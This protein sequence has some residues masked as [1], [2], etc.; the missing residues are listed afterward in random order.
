MGHL[1]TA[2]FADRTAFLF[3]T[4]S[5]PISEGHLLR[6]FIYT[7]HCSICAVNKARNR[8]LSNAYTEFRIPAHGEKHP[9]NKIDIVILY[10]KLISIL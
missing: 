10:V 1:P 5:Q 4:C 8:T 9:C 3:Q 2:G 7:V 6:K